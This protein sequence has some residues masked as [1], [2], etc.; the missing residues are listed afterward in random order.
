VKRPRREALRLLLVGAGSLLFGA[1]RA[2]SAAAPAKPGWDALRAA[3]DGEVVL[4]GA[5]D[6]EARRTAALWNARKPARQPD[7]LVRVASVGDVRETMRHAHMRGLK[8]AVRGG[9]HSFWGAPVRDGG[10]L[11]VPG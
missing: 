10:I 8:V 1:G 6:Y 7:A 11:L 3:I 2:A 5:A 9:G 4:K